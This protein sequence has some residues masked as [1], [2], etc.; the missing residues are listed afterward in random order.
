[1]SN[2]IPGSG[3]PRVSIVVATFNAQE[4]LQ[5]CF[6]SIKAQS[7]RDWELIVMD[8]ASIDE[9]VRVIKGNEEIINYWESAPDEGVYH[10]WNKALR[11]A[12]GEW[13]L[14]L[15]ADDA[16]SGPES[17]AALIAHADPEFDMIFARV[18]LV[19]STGRTRRIVGEAWD[20]RRLK[21]A[22]R[23]AHPGCLHHRRVFERHGEFNQQYKIAGDYEFL[24]R[25]GPGTRSCFVDRIIVDFSDGGMSNQRA[26]QVL[27]ETMKAQADHPE[28]GPFKAQLNYRF[29]LAKA[30]IKRL[31][32]IG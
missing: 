24:L 29:T 19:D 11:R 32:W 9:T 14:F 13:I 3:S 7:V 10:A 20:W 4:T 31:A 1:M 27:Q 28:I 21:Q 6:D 23:L 12:R 15:G 2:L 26:A 30:L 25:L 17:L 5:R 18:A 8:G 16:F 22:Q